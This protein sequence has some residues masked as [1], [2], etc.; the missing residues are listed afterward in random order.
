MKLALQIPRFNL[1]NTKVAEE[2]KEIVISAENAGFDTISVM[3]HFFQIPGVGEISDP[4]VEAYTTLGY[5]AAITSK[6]RLGVLVCGVIY[7]EPSFLVKQ[8]TT[9][10]VLSNGRTFLGIGAAWF[11]EEARGLGFPFPQLKTRFEMLKEALEITKRMWSEDNS[12]YNGKHYELQKPLNM[13]Q[14]IQ[15][16]HPPI[17]IGGSGEKK[18]LRY[19]AE[20]GD[21]CNLFGG[22]LEV[23]AHKLS[24]LKKHCDDIGR[25]YNEL[26]KT[27]LLSSVVTGQSTQSVIIHLTQLSEL[28]IDTAFLVI[29]DMGKIKPLEIIGEKVL[30]EVKDL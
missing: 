5:I 29:K 17:M 8:H 24:V 12:P 7:R 15:K 11:E 14:P 13:P 19:V 27:V 16:P 20:Y 4:M 3:D 23:V 26:E 1:E 10:D 25:D 28:G 9:L 6:V 22:N 2:L 18:T 30:P 21:A